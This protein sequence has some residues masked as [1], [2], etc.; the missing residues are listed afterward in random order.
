MLG[1]SSPIPAFRQRVEALPKPPLWCKIAWKPANLCN[2][3][4]DAICASQTASMITYT[5]SVKFTDTPRDR[6]QCSE[7]KL[8]NKLNLLEQTKLACHPLT[9]PNLR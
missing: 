7:Q 4:I 6:P 8:E 9:R 2:A 1:P 3:V 5:V